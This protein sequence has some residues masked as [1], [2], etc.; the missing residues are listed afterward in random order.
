MFGVVVKHVCSQQCFQSHARALVLAVHIGACG[1]SD[2]EHVKRRRKRSSDSSQLRHEMT[3]CRR[4]QS[5]A[6]VPAWQNHRSACACIMLAPWACLFIP[7]LIHFSPRL[8]QASHSTVASLFRCTYFRLAF[9]CRS[10]ACRDV[11]LSWLGS[12][13][14]LQDVTQQL[15]SRNGDTRSDFSSGSLPLMVSRLLMVKT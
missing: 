6:T 9:R 5:G 2:V 15:N 14:R 4:G 7:F 8:L 12:V 10:M 1:S 13:L 11:Q 3:C